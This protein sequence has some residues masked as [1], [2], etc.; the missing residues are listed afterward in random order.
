MRNGREK[1]D[2]ISHSFKMVDA[3][4]CHKQAKRASTAN[5]RRRLGTRKLCTT[6]PRPHADG[7]IVVLCSD[8]LSNQVTS[9]EIA[10]LANDASSLDGLCTALVQRALETGAPD[11]VTVVTAR[12]TTDKPD[13]PEKP[14]A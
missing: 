14:A 4:S 12:F 5:H 11:N 9:T 7:D 13:P 3:G 6:A 8:G 10:K 1:D 2:K